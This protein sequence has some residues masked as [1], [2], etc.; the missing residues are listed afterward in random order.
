MAPGQ[1]VTMSIDRIELQRRARREQAAFMGELIAAGVSDA[2]HAGDKML[3]LLRSIRPCPAA[4][5]SLR[6]DSRVM[7]SA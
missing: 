3:A 6:P 5:R 2:L 4:A 7:P 1:E